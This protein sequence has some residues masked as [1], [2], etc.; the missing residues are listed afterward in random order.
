MSADPARPAEGLPLPGLRWRSFSLQ[1]FLFTILPLTVL[2]L[3]IAFGS[4]ALH[5]ESMRALVGDRDL[6]AVRAAANS[7]SR[8]VELRAGALDLLANQSPPPDAAML[9]QAAQRHGFDGGLALFGPDGSLLAHA[10][11]AATPIR[12]LDALASA[13][14]PL[15]SPT[16]SVVPVRAAD[17]S[18]LVL[19][20]SPPNPSGQRAAG[21]YSLTE[22]AGPALSGVATGQT[23]V[24]LL[25]AQGEILFQAGHFDHDRP[26]SEHPGVTE[27]LRGESGVNY[28]SAASSGGSHSGGAGEHVV[29][30]SPVSPLGWGLVVEES[31]E[32]I[33]SPLLRTTQSAPL[34]LAPVL[35]LAIFALWFGARQIVQPLQALEGR[36][37][38]LA[39]GDFS[40][41]RQEVGG[42]SEI[43]R[44]QGTLAEM[45]D[46][47][48]AA[49]ESLHG[50]IGA[51][52][53]GVESE[54][55][56]LARE[57]H[58][59]TL[60]AL[61]ALNQHVQ[62]ALMQTQDPQQRPA[63]LDLQNR[64]GQ[65]ITNLRRAIGGLR[66][67]YLEDLGLVAALGMLAREAPQPGPEV[68]FA[69]HG[70][71]FRL[72]P[73]T[74][75]AFYRIAQEALNNA[76]HHAR[77]HRIQIELSF[78][79]AAARL[80]VRDDGQGFTPPDVPGTYTH[81]GHYGLL[82]MRERADLVNAAL[83]IRS[84]PNQGTTVQV[85]RRF[86]PVEKEAA[87]S[88]G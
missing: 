46:D 11:D 79:P 45:S 4:Q 47:L 60:Q 59:D 9:A 70:T 32:E 18:W 84:A 49:Q 72:P 29:A 2:L 85:E 41:I 5:H 1:L 23:T 7:L 48:Q 21:A 33:A 82:G 13:G 8:E 34:V 10:P 56:A 65:T 37:A 78:T 88:G 86:E 38:R 20:L 71:E 16:P 6:R 14:L 17:S 81:H 54:R 68:T 12:S 75:L 53:D 22:L 63:L 73:E 36:A 83:E 61:I 30:F 44:L 58:D 24:L 39:R 43:R 69:L 26:L 19:A 76:L 74:E 50:Y 62:L 35:L 64:V 40:A 66:P 27:V 55:T 31:W 15:D 77:A 57:L 87:H 28:T 51:L 25:S 67:I 3:L 80:T 52:T 42:I